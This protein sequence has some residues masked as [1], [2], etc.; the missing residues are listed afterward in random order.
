[1]ARM[2]TLGAE[3]RRP[4]ITIPRAITLAMGGVLGLYLVVGT[5]LLIVLGREGL[6]TS[7]APLVD[8]VVIS[9]YP[10]LIPVMVV[11]AAVASLGALIP[12]VLGVSRAT[13][14]MAADGHLPRALS[15]DH[16]RYGVPHRAEAVDA[17]VLIVLVLLVDLRDGVACSA[18]GLLIYYTITIAEAR[19]LGPDEDGSPL[20]VRR[21][22]LVGCVVLACSLPLPIVVVG[23]VVLGVG[24]CL[25]WL[26]ERLR[27]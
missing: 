19:R 6:T 26:H 12:L 27:G 14:A 17:A 9:G 5:G 10:A 18:F 22:G 25:W 21:G 13:A 15:D 11:G 2:A 20:V 8:A 24:A 16:E 23:M 4:R 3:V 7:R 1:Y